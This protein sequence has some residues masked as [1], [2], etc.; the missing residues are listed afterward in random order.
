[1]KKLNSLPK[2]GVDEFLDN[3]PSK[4]LEDALAHTEKADL[5]ES[6]KMPHNS[7]GK[8]E[9]SSLPMETVVCHQQHVQG[10]VAGKERTTARKVFTSL[11]MVG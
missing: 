6:N 5:M 3:K 10:P 11:Q 1:M 4:D 8:E 2:S 7:P 9:A